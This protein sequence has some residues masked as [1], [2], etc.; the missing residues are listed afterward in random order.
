MSLKAIDPQ[1]SF[2]HTS[3]VGGDLFGA[4]DRYRLFRERLLPKLLLLREK[5]ESLYCEQNGRPAV[6]PVVLAGVT[7]LQFMEKVPDRAAAAQVRYHLGWK[8]ALDLELSYEGFHP[9]VLVYFRDRLEEKGVERVIF[10]RIVELLIELGL[11]KSGGKQR[12]DSTHILG[13]VKEMSRLE[14]AVETMRLGLE[15]LE[16]KVLVRERPE[17]WERLWVL[18]VQS[19]LD[20]RLSKSE[21]E[22][23]YRQLGQDMKEV[24]E[25]IDKNSKLSELEAVKL[26]R[27]VFGEQFEVVEGKLQPSLR[28][29]PQSVQNPHDPDAHY[30]DKGKKQW[31]GYKVHVVESVNPEKP[32]KRKGDPTENFITEILT[33]EAAQDEMAGLAEALRRQEQHHE[34][35][36]EAIYLDGGYVTAKT[37]AEAEQ[38]GMGLLGPT[39]PDPHKGPYNVDHFSV[40]IE[41]RQAICPQGNLST[42]WSQIHDVYMGTEYY[43][44]EWGSQCDDCPVQKQ[45]TRSKNGRRILVV[46]LRHDL[47][48]K[49]RKEMREAD[50]SKNMH[51][52]NGIEGTHSELVRGHGLR[53]TKYRG[54]TRVGL[55]HYLMGA[56]CNVKRFLNLMAFQM[57]TPALSPA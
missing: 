47:V 15:A 57:R 48:E 1:I 4:A 41:Q 8:Y 34:I 6:D 50:F 28:R 21:R 31:V 30:A 35:K 55:S 11:V 2:Y 17:F 12:L 54:E 16:E 26:L 18:Y 20:W 49:R 32:A 37:L 13:Y 52:R 29:P 43:R 44:I 56:A 40:D 53:R 33:T 27:R 23:R 46:G 10:D 45:C 38:S 14:C 39:R 42:Q 19:Q 22:K 7:L 24:L 36:P 51:P 25:W 5:L 3:F 9:T